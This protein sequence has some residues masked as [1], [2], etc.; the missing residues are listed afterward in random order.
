MQLVLKWRFRI[1]I[2]TA[3]HE[4]THI[5]QQQICDKKLN[6]IHEKL[7][8]R[9]FGGL[10]RRPSNY[11]LIRAFTSALYTLQRL[12]AK[13]CAVYQANQ[14]CLLIEGNY[15]L[16]PK[17]RLSQTNL[18]Q[19]QGDFYQKQG[20]DAWNRRVPFY[21]TSN[22]SIANSYAHI[23]VTFMQ[24]L[25]AQ[26]KLTH[27][28]VY[29]VEMGCGS[30]TFSFYLLQRL[31]ELKRSLGDLLPRFVYVMSDLVA[32]NV[33]FW[34]QHKAFQ[35][36]LNEGLLDFAQ[37]D[38]LQDNAFNLRRGQYSLDEHIEAQYI[39]I[40]NYLLDTLA[41]DVFKLR[42]G[43]LY[44][45]LFTPEIDAYPNLAS[46]DQL[47]GL[48]SL[49][50]K[51]DYNPISWARYSEEGLNRFINDNIATCNDHFLTIPI[52]SIEAINTLRRISHDRMLML[53][54]DKGYI[55]YQH[56]Y[57]RFEPDLAFHTGCFSMM[58][59]F[60]A[61]AYYFKVRGGDYYHQSTQ[62]S[63]QTCL[64]WANGSLATMPL[65]YQALEM[66][67]NVFSPGNMLNIY[68]IL[69]KTSGYHRLN[70]I[71]ACLSLT[72]WDPQV[73]NACLDA[74]LREI[75]Q[76]YAA[77]AVQDLY[78]G[79]PKIAAKAYFIPGQCCT[80]AN[81]GFVL[82][83]LKYYEQALHYYTLSLAN[84]Q[85]LESVIYNMGLCYTFLNQKQHAI[86]KFKQTLELNPDYI[87]A[88]GWIAQLQLNN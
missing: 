17:V 75:H 40:A 78:Q 20:I 68:E 50:S 84:E 45:I 54:T 26:N 36:Y 14:E 83:E 86:E 9:K 27:E 74:I 81:V 5:I 21:A 87:L 22:P 33:D 64:Y 6:K 38:L 56:Y 8:C 71:V 32:S 31:A 42:N 46:S 48:K 34:E 25:K 63:I 49:D 58:V 12:L 62:H 23:I 29:I 11:P 7:P 16:K 18:W 67:L 15:N 55:D 65:T 57:G 76:P 19:K 24:E 61:L 4:A 69:A 79:L 82:Q 13:L 1:V 3:A 43:T 59:N 41:H 2:H 85:K 80:L 28:P 39:F 53:V 35:P 44:E 47:I 60:E 51:L 73:F 70:N 37:F 52:G 66:C 88:R 30:G 10:E 77:S 72:Q